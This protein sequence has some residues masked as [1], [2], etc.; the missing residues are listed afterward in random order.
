[1]KYKKQDMQAKTIALERIKILM[2]KAKGVFDKNPGL[3]NRYVTLSRKIAMKYKIRFP[4]ELKRLFCKH[5]YKFLKPGKTSRVRT[6]K[7]HVVI[8]CLNCKRFMRFPYR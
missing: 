1:M 6:H 7:G 4:R 2:N 5:C 3:A 8:Y